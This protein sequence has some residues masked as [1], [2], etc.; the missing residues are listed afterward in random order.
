MKIVSAM[1]TLLLL[2]PCS[3][4]ENHWDDEEDV[5]SSEQEQVVEPICDYDLSVVDT[6]MSGE[7]VFV[8]EPI[9]TEIQERM[10]GISL[11]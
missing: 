8:S 11:P 4:E 3:C 7:S 2:L 1:S 5:K 9:P 10:K 6:L